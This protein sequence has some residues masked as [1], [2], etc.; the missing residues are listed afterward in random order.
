MKKMNR[1]ILTIAIAILGLQA[2]AQTTAGTGFDQL[3]TF[4][5]DVNI[6]MGDK[7][8]DETSFN[9]GKFEFR[10]MID[11]KFSLGIDVSWNSYYM[12]K[13]TQTYHLEA[14]TDITTDLYRFNY[15]LP[16]AITADYYFSTKG[17]FTPYIGLGMGAMY[18][19]PK[20]YFNIYELNQEN[21]GFLMRPELGTIIRF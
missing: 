3:I 9:G 4:G 11:D 2:N 1:Y 17:L 16:I 19:Q 20:L 14:G 12:F 5:W 18:S 13:P 15:T 21:W 7:F 6:P 10:K 8:V